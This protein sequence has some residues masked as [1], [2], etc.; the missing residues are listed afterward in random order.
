MG[1]APRW[2]AGPA[3]GNAIKHPA[4]AV[5]W[6]AANDGLQ[7]SQSLLAEAV[8]VGLERWHGAPRQVFISQLILH[9]GSGREPEAF[10]PPLQAKPRGLKLMTCRR[11]DDRSICCRSNRA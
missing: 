2:G 9:A 5:A 7:I 4:A 6:I 1:G 10:P 8:L 11:D 3:L